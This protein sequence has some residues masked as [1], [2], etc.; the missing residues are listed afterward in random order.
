MHGNILLQVINVLLLSVFEGEFQV[1]LTPGP[2]NIIYPVF[3]CYESTGEPYPSL[4]F[5]ENDIIRQTLLF[6]RKKSPVA[7]PDTIPQGMRALK[8]HY[9]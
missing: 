9:Q 6:L 4:G 1:F 3:H 2:F 5:T 7:R 8:D